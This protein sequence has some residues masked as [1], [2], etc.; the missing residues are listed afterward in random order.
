MAPA[1]SLR[2]VNAART[3]HGATCS[4]DKNQR[5]TVLNKR[6]PFSARSRR[7]RGSQST[8]RTQRVT[9]ESAEGKQTARFTCGRRCEMHLKRRPSK[10]DALESCGATLSGSGFSLLLDAST[11][12]N[13]VLV[14]SRF[15]RPHAHTHTRAH[16]RRGALT[17]H[18]AQERHAAASSVES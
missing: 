10:R 15:R 14:A 8:T 2:R 5:A 12:H 18:W 9:H 3:K 17:R 16:T 4:T 7:A 6:E 13:S 11:R 1:S